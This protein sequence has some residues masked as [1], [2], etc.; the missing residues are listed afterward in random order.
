MCTQSL[1][2]FTEIRVSEMT[3]EISSLN[4]KKAGAFGNIPTKV[5]K[6]SSNICNIG[7]HKIWNSEVLEKQYFSQNLKLAHITPVYKKKDPTLAK[8][9][10]P[11]SVLP[12][13]FKVVERI[14]QNNYQLILNVLWLKSGESVLIIRAILERY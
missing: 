3:E 9:Y 12:T 2:H 4:S 7:H 14:T 10:R 1:F 5:I 11:G 8:E 13:V 6:I